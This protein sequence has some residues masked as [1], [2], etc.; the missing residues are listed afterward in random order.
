MAGNSQEP[1]NYDGSRITPEIRGDLKNFVPEIAKGVRA[2]AD[3]PPTPD[4][5]RG[6]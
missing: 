5:P 3:A 1:G 2:V 6:K 4:K